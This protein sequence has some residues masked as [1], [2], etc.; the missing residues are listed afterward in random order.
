VAALWR[1]ISVA[2]DEAVAKGEPF[3]TSHRTIASG[4]GVAEAMTDNTLRRR[5]AIPMPPGI[6]R[7]PRTKHGLPVPYIAEEHKDGSPNL[8]MVESGISGWCHSK[9]LC[10]I[11]GEK[12]AP[13]ERTFITVPNSVFGSDYG[14]ND[15]PMHEGC[16]RYAMRVCP[17]LVAPS[18]VSV[19]ITAP[20][21]RKR[22]FNHHMPHPTH[23][24]D[25]EVGY[26]WPYRPFKRVEWWSEGRQ[27]I[28][29]DE[30]LALLASETEKTRKAVAQFLTASA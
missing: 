6:A 8:G 27:I 10:S 29:R 15:P 30:I 26:Y 4:V 25:R 14:C 7:L 21:Y 5:L 1:A 19:V 22:C 13:A 11:C 28:D 18:S 23:F 9:G 12:L 20:R 3:S 16:A 17:H 2:Q 24:Q